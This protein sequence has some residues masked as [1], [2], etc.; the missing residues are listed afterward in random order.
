MD[1]NPPMFVTASSPELLREEMIAWNIRFG[2]KFHYFDI[3]ETKD[4]RWIAWFELS[5]SE[6]IQKELNDGNKQ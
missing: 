1:K 5:E 3:Q 2:K 4:G 6:R